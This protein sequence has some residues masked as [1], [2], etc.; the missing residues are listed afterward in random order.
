MDNEKVEDVNS[1][2]LNGN[3][4]RAAPSE[5]FRYDAFM[6]AMNSFAIQRE[7][8]AGMTEVQRFSEFKASE[9]SPSALAEVRVKHDA[10]N[11]DSPKVKV[12][13]FL[14]GEGPDFRIDTLPDK[15]DFNGRLDIAEL[16]FEEAHQSV[17]DLEIKAAMSGESVNPLEA[18]EDY[19]RLALARDELAVA[20]SNMSR[21]KDFIAEVREPLERERF[22]TLNENQQIAEFIASEQSPGFLAEVRAAYGYVQ[23]QILP[24]NIE[25]L[26]RADTPAMALGAVAESTTNSA[27]KP[28]LEPVELG[29]ETLMAGLREDD[30]KLG[31]DHL[32][33]TMRTADSNRSSQSNG[34]TEL[35]ANSSGAP[36]MARVNVKSV[37]QLEADWREMQLDGLS[38]LTKMRYS[39]RDELISEIR[40]QRTS[41]A[42]QA[43][44]LQKGMTPAE[45]YGAKGRDLALVEEGIKRLDEATKKLTE[46]SSDGSSIT[47]SIEYDNKLF[48]QHIRVGQSFD[49]S[50]QDDWVAGQ[51]SGGKLSSLDSIVANDGSKS[52]DV[53]R[54]ERVKNIVASIWTGQGIYTGHAGPNLNLKDLV[55]GE[56]NARKVENASNGQEHIAALLKL[57][58]EGITAKIN[59][60]DKDI[61]KLSASRPMWEKIANF[62]GIQVKPSE[63]TLQLK[64]QQ[65]I[66]R[67][68][69][70]ELEVKTPVVAEPLHKST[71]VPVDVGHWKTELERISKNERRPLSGS[72]FKQ[73][74]S[75]VES[76][77]RG[78]DEQKVRARETA[79]LLAKVHG[80]STETLF[81]D[82]E[83]RKACKDALTATQTR[84]EAMKER[85]GTAEAENVA[86]GAKQPVP[87]MR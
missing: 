8:L 49:G 79:G 12:E 9:E 42:S 29:F 35:G 32:M 44:A 74:I 38:N 20:L 70:D 53:Q 83:L 11:P 71:P 50:K 80:A 67:A 55:Q 68:L 22:D 59:Q 56:V 23:R 3:I 72:E 78:A 10:L 76:S 75:A 1:V 45:A 41:L 17:V 82:P 46:R 2:S 58:P 87:R 47:S 37:S 28:Q 16:E 5:Q 14:R 30:P 43:K 25:E 84:T 13:N 60:I 4:E 15:I 81:K 48:Q 26:L 65:Q 77:S 33:N 73:A 64:A 31:F 36:A 62:V 7:R 18:K 85:A 51:L 63:Q 86:P 40:E 54:S 39:V 52:V 6:T 27:P 69:R 61:Q 34:L 19:V 57:S 24:D 21:Y 66:Q